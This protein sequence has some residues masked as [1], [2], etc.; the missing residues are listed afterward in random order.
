VKSCSRRPQRR[1]GLASPPGARAGCSV[2]LP[3][4]VASVNLGGVSDFTRILRAIEEGDPRAAEQLLP[5]VYDKLRKLA[6]AGGQWAIW[7]SGAERRRLARLRRYQ[8][9]KPNQEIP[10]ELTTPHVAKKK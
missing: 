3:D 8:Q 7:A 5:P 10:E 4:A 1:C 9:A 2:S 6:A